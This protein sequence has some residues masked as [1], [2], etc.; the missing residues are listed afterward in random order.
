MAKKESINVLRK[1]ELD[2]LEQKGLTT[3]EDVVEFAKNNPESACH[4]W[5]DWDMK[6]AAYEHWLN[7][8]RKLIV[9]CVDIQPHPLSKTTG[10]V[11]TIPIPTY[12]SLPRD[13]KK[14]GG[15]YR[16]TVA[17]L[18]DVELR[19]ELLTQALDEFNYWKD[20]YDHLAELVPIFEAA[21]KIKRVRK[22][23]VVRAKKTKRSRK[24]KRELQPA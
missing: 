22:P 23:K 21:E 16:K 12:S 1:R 5:F 20:Q 17:V 10:L 15:G 13:R 3:A 8:A 6:K 9:V 2:K 11:H 19:E 18:S 24:S 4:S 14:K 7:R